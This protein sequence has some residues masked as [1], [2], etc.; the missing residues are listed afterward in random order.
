[1]TRSPNSRLIWLVLLMVGLFAAGALSQTQSPA[2][3]RARSMKLKND[4]N[5][6]EA[7]DGLRRLCLDPNS[8]AA[9][10]SQDLA[11]AV[12]CLNNLGRIQE[13]DD[14]LEKTIVAHQQNWR[15]LHAAAQQYLSVE[16]NGFRI[17][18][19]FE[20]GPH[21]GG[22]EMINSLERDRVRA[23]QLMQLALPLVQ[24]ENNKAEVSQFWMSLADMLLAN[25]GYSEAWRL[26]YLTDLAK[27]PDYVEGYAG[28]RESSGAPVDAEG[29]PVYHVVP[30]SWD[31]SETD[32]QRWRWALA[33]AVENSPD[34]L[35]AVR[36]HLAQFFEHQFGVESMAHG[37]WLG[38]GFGSGFDDD[39]KNDESGTYAIH[40]L[41]ENE[42][43]ARLASGI[44]RFDLP[45]EFNPI[46][47]YQQIIAEPRTGMVEPAMQ[48]LAEIFENRR[49]HSKAADFWRQSIRQ[50][51]AGQNRW[52]QDRLDQIIGN[53]GTFEQTASQPAGE[54][55]SVGFR[56]RNGKKVKFDAR[57]I[58]LDLLLDDLKAYLKSDPGNRIDWNKINLGNIGHR[59]VTE[60]ETKYLGDQVA[61]WDL[62]LDPRPNHFD[63]RIT[64]TTPLQKAGAYLLTATV[65]GG[66]TIKIVLWVADTAIVH[67]Q[68]SSKNLYF[69]AD[70]ASGQPIAEANVEFFGWQQ[71]HLGNNRYQVTTTNFSERTGPDGLT[72]PD[73]RD[74]KPDFPWLVIARARQSRL[75]FLG[76]TGVWTGQYHDAEYNQVKVFTITDRPVYRPNQKVQFKLWVERAQYDNDKSAFAGATIPIVIANPKGEKIYQQSIKADEF[77]GLEGE[78]ELPTDATL[79][80]YTINLDDG[81]NIP[82]TTISGNTFRVEEYKKPEFEVSIKAPTE[83]VMLGEKITAKIEAK[84]YFGSPVT[85]ATVKYKIL[86]S[87]HSEAWYPYAPWDWCYGPGYWWFAYDYS[88]YPGFRDWVGCRRPLP[89]WWPR[90]DRTPPEVVAEVAAERRRGDDVRQPLGATEA[91]LRER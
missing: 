58:K 45:D 72:I 34:R 88:W 60:N 5:F 80:Q 35:N 23:L 54:G 69:V 91:G 42:T 36:F 40:T 50:F 79:G 52:K 22:G 57:A 46:K 65:E 21:R 44:K 17:A 64:V 73:P 30:K 1:M 90:F 85:K 38:R 77:G 82:L 33:Q 43:I 29:Q 6:R 32:G 37:L 7:Y 68:L 67:K 75:A 70:A 83:P 59:L 28:Y 86:R 56:F 48:S 41:K 53:W 14:L 66:K 13:F 76:F 10:V 51:G 9:T 8:G 61:A 47:L 2:A 84:Y 39:A 55:A 3:M 49:Q 62:A 31:A 26:Q 24:N 25:R 4:G 87:N 18:G 71:R 20:R 16:H 27:L 12:E 19:K 81:H 15:L 89:I 11:S 78:I 74:L 63:R